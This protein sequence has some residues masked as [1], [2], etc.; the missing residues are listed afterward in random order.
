MKSEDY[1]QDIATV[2]TLLTKQVHS[3]IKLDKTNVVNINMYVCGKY[4]ETA[5]VKLHLTFFRQYVH[6]TRL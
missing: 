5:I 4:F 2:Q 6:Y 3:C 1:G